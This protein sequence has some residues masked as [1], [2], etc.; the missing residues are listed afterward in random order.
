M[1]NCGGLFGQINQCSGQALFSNNNQGDRKGYI[2]V[3]FRGL[4]SMSGTAELSVEN[5]IGVLRGSWRLT[6][7][8]LYRAPGGKPDSSI[9]LIARS[10][11][12]AGGS[13]K[14]S[15]TETL[16]TEKTY[17]KGRKG[18]V[19]QHFDT[20]KLGE[21]AVTSGQVVEYLVRLDIESYSSAKG[22][23]RLL[24]NAFGMPAV[25]WD[26]MVKICL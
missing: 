6:G 15:T 26:R 24:T 16:L 2:E 4:A 3:A 9:K 7:D 19:S 10:R 18:E 8:Y 17:G 12:T 23:V 5:P 22:V 14:H 25:T 21:F 1:P 11:V 20:V 13:V